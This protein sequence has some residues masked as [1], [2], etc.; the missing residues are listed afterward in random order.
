MQSQKKNSGSYLTK[1]QSM[2]SQNVKQ[3]NNR[4]LSVA[5]QTESLPDFNELSLFKFEPTSMKENK[6]IY[7]KTLLFMNAFHDNMN[8]ALEKNMVADEV[9]LDAEFKI[10]EVPDYFKIF[11]L[12]VTQNRDQVI[13][14][15]QVNKVTS[16]PSSWEVEA[17][18]EDTAGDGV[19]AGNEKK[20]SDVQLLYVNSVG[21]GPTDDTLKQ[22]NENENL[23]KSEIKEVIDDYQ[24]TANSRTTLTPMRLVK[25][26]KDVLSKSNNYTCNTLYEPL[27]ITNTVQRS[28]NQFY[29]ESIS[30]N[31]EDLTHNNVQ[32]IDHIEDDEIKINTNL[33]LM[34]YTYNKLGTKHKKV[35]SMPKTIFNYVNKKMLNQVSQSPQKVNE[36]FKRISGRNIRIS[37]ED[38]RLK[39]HIYHQDLMSHDSFCENCKENCTKEIIQEAGDY[40]AIANRDEDWNIEMGSSSDSGN[41]NDE[42]FENLNTNGYVLWTRQD[43]ESQV[44]RPLTEID[45]AIK[46]AKFHPLELTEKDRSLIDKDML[47]AIGLFTENG[48]I[49][50]TVIGI[51]EEK[52][53]SVSQK[54]SK[55]VKFRTERK[56]DVQVRFNNKNLS[57]NRNEAD[58]S[59]SNPSTEELGIEG[60][61][62]SSVVT[63]SSSVSESDLTDMLPKVNYYE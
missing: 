3:S 23:D 40:R 19:S 13:K 59:S 36:M 45:V 56:L 42:E 41:L 30:L 14:K 43:N 49:R 63:V 60:S 18:L 15:R 20:K 9:V 32:S 10:P 4:K 57:A 61:I 44:K 26:E 50:P 11:E 12:L 47:K 28:P 35:N 38:Y 2:V 22:T 6:E 27:R 24:M 53:R 54:P 1:H 52:Q 5:S 62:R 21:D 29:E 39:R 46:P 37:S 31:A 25:S 16:I 7:S 48:D 33:N 58:D 17:K 8:K 34:E 55:N 51:L